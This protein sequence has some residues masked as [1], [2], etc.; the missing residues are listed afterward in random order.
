MQRKMCVI[1]VENL[2][3]PLDRHVWQQAK[4]LRD[5]GWRVLVICP[6]GK[7]DSARFELLEGIEIHRH[8][9]HEASSTLGYLR[10]YPQA[11]F[12]ESLLLLKLFVRHRFAVIHACN[13]PDLLLPFCLFYK[14]LGVKLVFDQHDLSPEIMEVRSGRG[15]LYRTM[16]LLEWCSFKLADAVLSSNHSFR[17]IALG[18]GGKRPD[19]VSVVHTIPDLGHLRRIE[20]DRG[21]R[22]GRSVVIG[23][24]GIIG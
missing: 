2:P 13:P 24:L 4:A 10:E 17:E 18:R 8:P 21:L 19:Q 20:P 1:V 9:L 3:V 23:Y 5:D 22:D 6:I 15:L 12:H 7:K 11:I 16:L 14:L